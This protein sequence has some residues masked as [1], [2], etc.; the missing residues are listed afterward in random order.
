MASNSSGV[1][2]CPFVDL[3]YSMLLHQ[4]IFYRFQCR[5]N[6]RGLGQ[7]VDAVAVILDHSLYSPDLAFN[8]PEPGEQR[9]HAFSDFF[10][11][12]VYF[13]ANSI[14]GQGII[15]GIK[16]RPGPEFYSCSYKI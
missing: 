16:I 8:P 4:L 5:D 6:G 3:A 9:V 11:G 2:N 7:N 14:P 10:T 15:D 13:R 1:P 12:S